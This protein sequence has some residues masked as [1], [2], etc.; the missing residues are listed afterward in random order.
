M[1][2]RG[3][4][5]LVYWH[6]RSGESVTSSGQ[7]KI[8]AP[9]DNKPTPNPLTTLPATIDQNPNV[10][11]WITPPIVKMAAPIHKVPFRPTMSPTEPAA[12]DV[13]RG[14]VKESMFDT[15]RDKQNA[16]ISSTA[17]IVPSSIGPGALKYLMKC[18]PVIIP[19]ITLGQ[20]QSYE[21]AN[22]ML[23]KDTPGHI[24]TV[25]AK[26]FDESMRVFSKGRD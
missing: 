13:P 21:P 22:S 9:H 1:I 20:N 18:G 12:R 26:E 17:T 8:R 24:Q 7:Q 2:W 16:P 23:K 4:F 10:Q 11:V 3:Y 6:N 14:G 25:T 19:D 15:K 5:A